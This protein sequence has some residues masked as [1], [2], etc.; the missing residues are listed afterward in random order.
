[1]KLYLSKLHPDCQWLFQQSKMKISSAEEVWYKKEPLGVNSLG[2]M[3]Q[4][5]SEAAGL[6]QAYTNHCVRATT[7][8]LLFN[9]GVTTH[10]IQARTGHRTTEGLQPYVGQQTARQRRAEAD[11]LGSAL[12]GTGNDAEVRISQSQ[13]I[14]TADGSASLHI[15]EA[16]TGGTSA[17]V[18]PLRFDNCTFNINVHY[19]NDSH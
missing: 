3:M 5:I 17:G 8:T 1:M 15:M 11:I 7:V 4:P 16:Q 10:H 9:T 12:R 19:H 18:V 6:S 2:K 14:Q 13:L